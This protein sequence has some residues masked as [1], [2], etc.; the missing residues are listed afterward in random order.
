MFTTCKVSTGILNVY[1]WN[2][3]AYSFNINETKEYLYAFYTNISLCNLIQ[4]FLTI[5]DIDLL[6]RSKKIQHSILFHY[7]L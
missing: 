3:L 6:I 2:L 5:L 1:V 4:T 7:T